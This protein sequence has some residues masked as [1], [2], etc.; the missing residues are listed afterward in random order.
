MRVKVK[1]PLDFIQSKDKL[2]EFDVE[3]QNGAFVVKEGSFKQVLKRSEY[4][5]IMASVV[6]DIKKESSAEKK[7]RGRPKAEEKKE[8]AVEDFEDEAPI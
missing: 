3:L 6:N 2:K 8:D 4:E 5:K 1:E 7:G